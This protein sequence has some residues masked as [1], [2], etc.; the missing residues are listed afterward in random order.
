MR[1]V[2]C[3]TI[4]TPLEVQNRLNVS[5]K[6]LSRIVMDGKIAG[7]QYARA[8]FRYPLSSV[9][10]YETR[11]HFSFYEKFSIKL[12]CNDVLTLREASTVLNISHRSVNRYVNKTLGA[13][14]LIKNTFYTTRMDL[15]KFLENAYKSY[16]MT[17]ENGM[18]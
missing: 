1:I 16:M 8:C 7:L 13:A 15:I 10:D 5:S 14:K 18:L 12:N 11:H 2:D 17:I 4:L 6:E 9:I 3:N